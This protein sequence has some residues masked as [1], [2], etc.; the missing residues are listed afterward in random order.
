[1]SDGHNLPT[2]NKGIYWKEEKEALGVALSKI[3]AGDSD[4][5]AAIKEAQDT[6]EFTV[7]N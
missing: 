2:I 1:M 4:M 5:D 7:G 6:V 3:I